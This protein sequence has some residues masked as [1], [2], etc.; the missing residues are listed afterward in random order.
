MVGAEAT[1]A[2]R[3]ATITDLL[4]QI[5]RLEQ[6]EPEVVQVIVP[7]EPEAQVVT[8]QEKEGLLLRVTEL[9][10]LLSGKG[11]QLTVSG[12]LRVLQRA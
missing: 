11:R 6:R 4:A 2:E 8:D 9:Q 1:I 10:Q 12:V 3:D 7:T 5:A